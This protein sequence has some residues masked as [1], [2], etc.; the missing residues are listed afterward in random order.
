MPGGCRWCVSSLISFSNLVSYKLYCY[1]CCQGCFHYTPPI[2]TLL[3]AGEHAL[4]LTFEPSDNVNFLPVRCSIVLKIEKVYP[5]LRWVACASIE[6]GTILTAAQL[7]AELV[8]ASIEGVFDFNPPLGTLLD[9]GPQQSLL[10]TFIPSSSNYE[11]SEISN[12]ITVERRRPQLIWTPPLDL[13]WPSPL[14]GHMLSA[15]CNHPY[16][17]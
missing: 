14:E 4:A 11:R 6:Y 16:V 12:S 8:D 5:S 2:G 10:A 1:C 7:N 17:T 9:V 13:T 3:D 15:Q